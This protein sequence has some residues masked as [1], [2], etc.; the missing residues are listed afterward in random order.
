MLVQREGGTQI[1]AEFWYF[2]GHEHS[3]RCCDVVAPS[4]AAACRSRGWKVRDCVVVEIGKIEAARAKRLAAQHAAQ[5]RRRDSR[6]HL[7]R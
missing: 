3:G 1:M 7:S 5:Q 6:P 4:P 2:V